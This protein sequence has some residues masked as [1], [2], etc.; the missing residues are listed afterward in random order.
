MGKRHT[1]TLLA[2]F[3]TGLA[4]SVFLAKLKLQNVSFIILM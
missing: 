3:K 4:R 1:Q 2:E